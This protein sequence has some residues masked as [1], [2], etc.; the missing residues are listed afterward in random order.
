[1]SAPT[2]ST[3][4]SSVAGPSGQNPH[5]LVENNEE[6]NSV[7]IKVGMVGD[8]QIGKTSLMVKYVEGSFD[9]DYIQTLGS[10][11]M[12]VKSLIAHQLSIRR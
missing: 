9:E 11:L 8:S 7:V 6:K 4:S 10:Y 5:P 12:S 3:S 2:T 1:M